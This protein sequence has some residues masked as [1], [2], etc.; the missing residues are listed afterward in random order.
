V[1]KCDCDETAFNS[2]VV[3]RRSTNSVD[4]SADDQEPVDIAAMQRVS[5]LSAKNRPYVY[6]ALVNSM[7]EGW[8]PNRESVLLLIDVGRRTDWPR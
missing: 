6:D 8:T 3:M 7:I 1:G 4:G 5:G 2:G